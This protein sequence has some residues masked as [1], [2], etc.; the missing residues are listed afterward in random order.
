MAHVAP[1][2]SQHVSP[3]PRPI[4]ISESNLP[5]D[6]STHPR[7][8]SHSRSQSSPCHSKVSPL[9]PPPYV[10]PPSVHHRDPNEPLPP[11]PELVTSNRPGPPSDSVSSIDSGFR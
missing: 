10:P 5:R 4:S 6:P 3:D 1:P 2:P 8:V 11:P 7:H 9:P